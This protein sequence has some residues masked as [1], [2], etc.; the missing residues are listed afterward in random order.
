MAYRAVLKRRN[1]LEL[2]AGVGLPTSDQRGRGRG[3]EGQ[4]N[5]YCQRITIDNFTGQLVVFSDAHFWPNQDKTLAHRAL[6]EVIKD[7]K[8]KLVIANGDIFDGARL[9]RFPRNG[10]EEQ[11]RVSDELETAVEYMN[12]IRHLCRGARLLRTIGNHCI[13]FDRYLAT[14]ASEMENV[15]GARLSDHMPAWQECMSIAINGNTMV[16]HRINGGIH[17]GYRNTLAA[18]WSTFTGHTHLCE[19]KP[20]AD[21]NGVRFGVSTGSL[22]DVTTGPQF[23]YTEDSPKPWIS[24]FATGTFDKAGRLLPPSVCQVMGPDAIYRE[25]IV[26]SDAKRKAV[27]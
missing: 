24:G 23:F 26:V 6:L 16:K 13:R 15:A 4:K 14:N 11:P 7:I 19:V 27:A 22:A 9:S 10:W 17:S 21:Y 25:R 1:A 3:D 8:P 18:G 20:W 5:D 2:K 12:E